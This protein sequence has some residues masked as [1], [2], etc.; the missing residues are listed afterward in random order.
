MTMLLFFVIPCH[1]LCTMNAG[2]LRIP[3]DTVKADVSADSIG[4]MMRDG[5]SLKEVVI[6]GNS[7]YKEI[8]MRSAQNTLGVTRGYVE[9]NFGGS[10]MQTLE[11]LP[12]VKAMA[13]GSG[14]SKP[15][16]RG[17][18]FNRVLVAEN[19][20]RHEGQQWGG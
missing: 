20:I 15:V 6:K 17:L 7:G 5:I 18:G 11:R 1:A 2:P 8:Q 14:A 13:V 16:I 10:L 9:D 19:G 4:R 12:G 3:V